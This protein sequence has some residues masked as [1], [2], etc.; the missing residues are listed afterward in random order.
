MLLMPCV[1]LED[2]DSRLAYN[3]KK[4]LDHD[5][6]YW[7]LDLTNDISIPV[8]AAIAQNR[9][10]R[11]FRFGYGCHLN[12]IIACNR[13]LLE[14]C[15]IISSYSGE[16]NIFDF[17]AVQDR[18]YLFPAEDKCVSNFKSYN[19]MPDSDI[20]NDIEICIKK[21]KDC[22]FDLFVL[23]ASRPELPVNAVKVIVPGLC[24]IWPQF[25]NQRLYN[26]PSVLDIRKKKLSENELNNI[27]L[28]V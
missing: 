15:Q 17:N 28:F 2:S 1:K 13:A 3:I 19:F 24:H 26:L 10:N 12:P 22:G 6:N 5:W 8:M 9:K 16:K 20:C 14:L 7:I 18:P 23:N 11:S 4:D 27:P 21:I 25:G